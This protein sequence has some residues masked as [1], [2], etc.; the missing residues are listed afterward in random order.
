M[1][2]RPRS[3]VVKKRFVESG[4]QVKLL[5]HRSSDSV[6]FVS[7]PTDRSSTISRQRSLSYPA[8]VCERHAMYFPSGE[9]FG[10]A[11]APGEVEILRASPPE[12][13]ITYRSEFVL[14]AGTESPFME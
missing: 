12:I 4:L 8:R 5:T 14:V 2:C 6:R 9:Y 11:S 3:F 13:E 1:P 10:L 7:R